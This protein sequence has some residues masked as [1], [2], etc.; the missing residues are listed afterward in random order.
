MLNVITLLSAVLG[1]VFYLP[2]IIGL[3]SYSGYHTNVSTAGSRSP[4]AGY[5]YNTAVSYDY[6]RA[7]YADIL[8][9]SAT[10]TPEAYTYNTVL[11]HTFPGNHLSGEPSAYS[12]DHA[13][14]FSGSTYATASNHN[15]V[16]LHPEKARLHTHVSAGNIQEYPA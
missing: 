8:R 1:A 9:V 7:S 11:R 12:Y 10:Y 5:L 13:I 6:D 3:Y 4:C 2:G 15:H 14:Q 16:V